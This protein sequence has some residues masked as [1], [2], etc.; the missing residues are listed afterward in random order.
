MTVSRTTALA[1]ALLIALAFAAILVGE[2]VVA[3]VGWLGAIGPAPRPARGG[4][5]PV[6]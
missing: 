6:A 1:L 2:R 5:R 4:A 3:D